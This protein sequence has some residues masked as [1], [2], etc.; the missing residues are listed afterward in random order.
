MAQKIQMMLLDDIDGSEAAETVRFALDGSAYE[1]DLSAG[2][3][4]QLRESVARYAEHARKVQGREAR[5]ARQGSRQPRQ[6]ATT[7]RAWLTDNG[8]DLKDRGRIPAN[9]IA[10]YENKTP[11]TVAPEASVP[12]DTAPAV[13][14]QA[15][16]QQTR[17]RRKNA[18]SGNA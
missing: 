10:A 8:Y 11:A 4:G 12:A 14:F 9:L 5:A 16:K 3:A 6:D 17:S 2:H 7:I 15:P 18:D 1:I 13:A